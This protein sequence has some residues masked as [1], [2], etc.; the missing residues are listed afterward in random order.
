[1]EIESEQ[2][3][4]PTF[5]NTKKAEQAEPGLRGVGSPAG[6]FQAI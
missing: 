1:M 4:Q 5:F 6:A 3:T 2:S